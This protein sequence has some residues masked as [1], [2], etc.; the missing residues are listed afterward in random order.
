MSGLETAVIAAV[1][2]AVTKEAIEWIKSRGSEFS[3][4]DWKQTA[5]P[6]LTQVRATHEQFRT[7]RQGKE[8]RAQLQ[9]EIRIAGRALRELEYLGQDRGFDPDTIDRFSNLADLLAEWHN[10]AEVELQNEAGPYAERFEEQ[11]LAYQES[12]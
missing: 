1:G 12:E 7:A 6:I 9:R 8:E 11:Y 4:S 3:E 2:N 5:A 10:S